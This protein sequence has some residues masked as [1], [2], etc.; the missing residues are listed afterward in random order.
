MKSLNIPL[1]KESSVLFPVLQRQFIQWLVRRV[2]WS[3]SR[4]MDKN[5][6]FPFSDTFLCQ[7]G[8]CVPL[9][10][11]SSRILHSLLNSSRISTGVQWPHARPFHS[12]VAISERRYHGLN[13]FKLRRMHNP[14]APFCS[15]H[16]VAVVIQSLL[17]TFLRR[18][19]GAQSP[20]KRCTRH[21]KP[22]DKCLLKHTFQMYHVFSSSWLQMSLLPHTWKQNQKLPC[23]RY[24]KP[25]YHQETRHVTKPT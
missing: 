25:S 2:L 9:H 3:S 5:Q 8:G 1:G 24:T 4:H 14:T 6:D 13:F 23:K 19:F 20:T 12:S 21:V 15:N 11:V 18:W 22:W 16:Y 7:K 17:P 10:F